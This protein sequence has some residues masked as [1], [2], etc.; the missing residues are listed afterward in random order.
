MRKLAAI[1]ILA[2]TSACGGKTPAP[3][4]TPNPG[5]SETITGRERFGWNQQADG[6]AELAAFG[7]T[8]FVDGNRFTV[9]AV[10]CGTSPSTD[11]FACSGQLPAMSNGAHA[12]Q[13]ATFM[14]ENGATIESERSAALNVVVSASSAIE[15]SAT[16]GAGD[17]SR[18]GERADSRAGLPGAKPAG[19]RVDG[20]QQP[21]DLAI[22]PDGRVFVAEASGRISIVT[23]GRRFTALESVGGAR[24][25]MLAIAL[26]PQV[27]RNGLVYVI[28][29]LDSATPVFQLVRYREVGGTLAE[30]ATL[31]DN[32]PLDTA[33]DRPLDTAR[34][35]L[36]SKM[37]P[38]DSL[39]L[40][41]DRPAAALRFGPDGR[42]YAAFEER[43]DA[44][45][46]EGSYNGKILR[47][48]PDGTTPR[49]QRGGSP[50]FAA[51]A[52]RPRG[53]TWDA[54]G[55]LWIVDG[56]SMGPERLIAA[57]PAPGP[58]YTLPVPFGAAS[59][60]F[61]ST[62]DLLLGAETA[63]Y[64]LRVRFDPKD[65][66]R[67]VGTERLLEGEVEGIRALAVAADGTVIVGTNTALIDRISLSR[68]D[69]SLKP[70]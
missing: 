19:R 4:T 65:R 9:G 69:R 7:Y 42:L 40:A 16:S 59:A 21:N 45:P 27:A 12:L 68:A 60:V 15:A 37:R 66:R 30:A 39:S 23:G 10:S 41:R 36:A 14:T 55:V 56:D 5:G 49:D 67:V 51:G 31:L 35:G 11:G 64:I 50:V 13:L 34:D 8:I 33:R 32:V 58:S 2:A 38:L 44:T 48:N 47:L 70:W 57:A 29:A 52:R 24:V 3:P 43:R 18:G 46:A 54:D 53:L 63:G 17:M 20:L 25:E 62:G 26:D 22:A 6:T 61:D 28:R 1:L